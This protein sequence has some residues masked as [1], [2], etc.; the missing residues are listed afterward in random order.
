M[1]QG[2]STH[3]TGNGRAAALPL[4]TGGG[5][6]LAEVAHETRNMVTALGLYCD[7]LAEPGVLDPAH[8]HYA[9]EL[10]LIALAS[11]G[12]ADKLCGLGAE[13]DGGGRGT[14]AAVD[15]RSA[16]EEITALPGTRRPLRPAFA[17]GCP[18]DDLGA[19]LRAHASLLEAVAGSGIRVTVHAAATPAQAV[20]LTA[21]DLTRVLVNLVKNAA[22]AMPAGGAVAISLH[23]KAQALVLAVE[24]SGP[25]IPSERLETI[26]A[27]GFTS[28]PA[29]GGRAGSTWPRVHRGLGL[30]ITRSVVEGAGGRIRAANRSRGGARFE[31]ELPIRKR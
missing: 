11:R 12:L 29:A 15:A 31:I 21:E 20:W 24:D 19:E 3:A 23:R 16:G 27:A 17:P 1:Q 25:G 2:R 10:R 7:L 30:S 28:K 13:T 9:Q 6:A 22:E 4:L 8:L 5:V 18:I 14:A 26:F